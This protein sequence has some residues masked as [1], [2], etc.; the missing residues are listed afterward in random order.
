MV[1]TTAIFTKEMVCSKCKARVY[2]SMDEKTGGYPKMEKC[3]K[4]GEKN[5][6]GM[7]RIFTR[8]LG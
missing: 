4:C 2:Q 7:L 8:S 3:P 1:G 6:L 5:T